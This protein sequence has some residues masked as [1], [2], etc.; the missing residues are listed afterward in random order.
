MMKMQQSISI[1]ERHCTELD[2]NKT[3][4]VDCKG[5]KIENIAQ[6]LMHL[7][8][9]GIKDKCDYCDVEIRTACL[10]KQPK[11]AS[12]TPVKI[13]KVNTLTDSQCPETNLL[14]NRT[15]SDKTRAVESKFILSSIFASLL[16]VVMTFQ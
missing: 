9:A 11:I 12:T 5:D 7:G 1:R 4:H 8:M 10:E 16:V 6:L 13:A 14:K 15:S 3:Q 2:A